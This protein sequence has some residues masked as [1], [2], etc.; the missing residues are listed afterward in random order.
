MIEYL[1]IGQITNAHGI[2]GEVKVFSLTD[3]VKRFSKLKSAFLKV[4]DEYVQVEIERVKYINDFAI[5]KL[6]GVNDMNAA[7]KYKNE[8]L[9]IDREHAVKPP[10]DSY[11]IADLIGMKV[12]TDE[13][14]LLG[15]IISV[16]P[17]GSNDVYEVKSE[18][19]KLVLIPAIKDV[20]LE[21]DVENKKMLVKLLEGLI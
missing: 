18:L 2:K 14:I 21:V 20:V 13:G 10:K 5:L 15:E 17:T 12:S 16:F 8:Y 9:Y 6:A 11:F 19:G 1:K 7:L 3:N 4:K